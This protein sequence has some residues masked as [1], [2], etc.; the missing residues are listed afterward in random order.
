MLFNRM[1]QV[2]KD[3]RISFNHMTDHL[4]LSF[5]VAALD[6]LSVFTYFTLLGP[7]FYSIYEEVG[8]LIEFFTKSQGGASTEELLQ[9]IPSQEALNSILGSMFFN[10]TLFLISLCVAWVIIQGI[11]WHLTYRISEHKKGPSLMNYMKRFAGATGV[12]G[13]IVYVALSIFIGAM[14][15]PIYS[16]I[17]GGSVLLVNILSLVSYVYFA[18]MVFFFPIIISV[19][20]SA[21]FPKKNLRAY[22]RDIFSMILSRNII[23]LIAI[24]L[25]TSAALV[26]A[27][28]IQK[29]FSVLPEETMVVW[30]DPS[31]VVGF[32]LIFGI[33]VL[34]RLVILR[35][36]E[37]MVYKRRNED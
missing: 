33:T 14:V 26:I 16:R 7:F 19:T 36:F 17:V 12:L 24:T 37:R 4:G 10:A 27:N 21:I 18:L 32:I 1:K 2:M 11:A 31:I 3:I 29:A 9:I 13:I 22:R 28:I 8:T 23:I 15:I 30:I 6:A 35:T 25:I 20:Y 34:Y 5:A